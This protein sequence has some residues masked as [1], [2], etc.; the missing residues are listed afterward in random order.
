MPPHG[1]CLAAAVAYN[2]FTQVEWKRMLTMPPRIL[3]R[4][5]RHD[6]EI[7]ETVEAGIELRGTEVKSVRAGKVT[8]ADSFARIR[9]GE[10]FLYGAEISPYVNAGYAHHDPARPRRLLM[11]SREIAR[12]A[13]KI[14]QKGL[15]LVPLKMYFK[16][17]WVKVEI[18]L[19]RGK[20]Q[21]DKREAIKRRETAREISRA[22]S[23]R[24]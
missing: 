15:T 17:G 12:L 14:S 6:Y 20:R 2:H 16:R 4:K 21:Y 5:A 3:N 24:R 9:A 7:L 19:A 11:H 1:G 13:G 23:R 10:I 8:L 18:G 22:V